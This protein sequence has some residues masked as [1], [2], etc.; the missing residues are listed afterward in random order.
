MGHRDDTHRHGVGASARGPAPT[1]YDRRWTGDLRGAVRCAA[2]LLALLLLTDDL[3]GDLTPWRAVLWLA[4]AVVLFVVLCPPRVSAGEG[5]LASRG[6]L[7]TRRVR[8]DR[9]VS[10]R[11]VEDVSGRLVLRDA[12]GGRVELSPR[13]LLDNPGLWHRL[14]EDARRSAAH[15]SL[16]CGTIAL[17]EVRERIDRE[18]ARAVFRVSGLE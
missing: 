6:P 14:D 9:L 5:W 8:T 11:R 17:G 1:A 12:F 18:T 2:L 16:R 13:V 4:L 15:G 10:V 7:R 3:A